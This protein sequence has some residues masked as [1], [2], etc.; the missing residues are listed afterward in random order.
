VSSPRSRSAIRVYRINRDATLGEEVPQPGAIDAGIFAHQVRV[1]ANNL[2][3]ILVTRGNDPMGD[4]PEDSGALAAAALL[5][6][7]VQPARAAGALSRHQSLRVTVIQ[8]GQEEDH[9][10]PAT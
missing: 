4:K 7:G 10:Y 3:A 5:P 8:Y 2:L 1:T 6:Q 9:D